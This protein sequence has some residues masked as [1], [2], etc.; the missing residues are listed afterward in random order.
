MEWNEECERVSQM[1]ARKTFRDW[2]WSSGG[3]FEAHVQV[4]RL[5]VFRALAD[6]DPAKAKLSTW[7]G[8]KV[9]AEISAAAIDWNRGIKL[10]RQKA[11]REDVF[12]V[13]GA[14]TGNDGEEIEGGVLERA[15]EPAL[16]GGLMEEEVREKVLARFSVCYWVVFRRRVLEGRTL[17]EVG[18]DLEISLE[19]VR[20][21]QAEVA[22]YL[23]GALTEMAA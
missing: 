22:E 8:W 5:G 2:G 4:C 7:A 13:H 9:K 21:M 20:Q 15:D 12:W 11:K 1:L 19:R 17:A 23:R 18:E 3:D 6:F 14:P 16:D 10:G